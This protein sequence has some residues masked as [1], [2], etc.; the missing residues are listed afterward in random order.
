[1]DIESQTHLI[2]VS[3]IKGRLTLN[4][5]RGRMT[6]T[7]PMMPLPPDDLERLVYMITRG[8]LRVTI[9]IENMQSLALEI[10]TSV[11]NRKDDVWWKYAMLSF[12]NTMG[13]CERALSMPCAA[14]TLNH[15]LSMYKYCNVLLMVRC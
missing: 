14:D 7:L 4:V 12:G 8:P 2:F 3:N 1:M 13:V 10:L 9:I 6:F 11:L 5:A 15:T